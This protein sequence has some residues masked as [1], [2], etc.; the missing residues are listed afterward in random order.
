MGKYTIEMFRYLQSGEFHGK[1][2]TIPFRD[3]YGKTT[4]AKYKLV[5]II[6]HHVKERNNY[7]WRLDGRS[8]RYMQRVKIIENDESHVLYPQTKCRVIK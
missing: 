7:I 4:V 3:R 2:L 5:D 1:K 6:E 8:I